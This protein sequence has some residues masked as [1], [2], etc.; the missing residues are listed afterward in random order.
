MAEIGYGRSRE[1]ICEVVKSILDNDGGPNPGRKW[2]LLFKKRHPQISLH[3]PE[4]LQ[5]CRIKCCTAEAICDWF[6]DFDQFGHPKD[7]CP[8]NSSM[9]GWLITLPGM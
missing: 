8:L 1:Q 9:V 7:G 2:W 5:L 6:T 3:S 4:P